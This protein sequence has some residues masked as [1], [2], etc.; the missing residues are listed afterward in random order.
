M[1]YSI[2]ILVL[3]SCIIAQ[4]TQKEKEVKTEFSFA[5][6]ATPKG[7]KASETIDLENKGVGPIQS[8]TISEAINTEM[9]SSGAAL[10]GQ[11]CTP[12]HKLGT[13]FIGPPPNGILERR[14]PEWI[15]NMILNPEEM[16]QKDALAQALFMEFNGQLMTNQ[17]LTKE[18]ARAILEYFR[19]LN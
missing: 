2:L 17:R 8:V 19:T 13:T 3:V 5:K 1:K 16:L 18:E 4:C 14:T 15:M 7:L 12:C 11:K 6:Q 10:Y 9:A